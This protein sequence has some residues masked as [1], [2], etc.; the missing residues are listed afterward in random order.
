MIIQKYKVVVR[1]GIDK[2]LAKGIVEFAHCCI[3]KFKN[4][5]KNSRNKF[6]NDVAIDCEVA[7]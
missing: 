1:I 5:H 2:I 6:G 7:K 3:V 4:C